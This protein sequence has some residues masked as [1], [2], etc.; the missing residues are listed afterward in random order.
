[1]CNEPAV[2]LVS[3][4]ISRTHRGEDHWLR[5]RDGEERTKAVQDRHRI[6]PIS[7]R[8]TVMSQLHG[9]AGGTGEPHPAGN[10]RRQMFP[11]QMCA[12]LALL[13][14]C[15]ALAAVSAAAG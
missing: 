7:S 5:D 14:P 1:M 2:L 12:S 10:D 13:P 6:R 3:E 8:G 11:R 9:D 4:R 15:Q